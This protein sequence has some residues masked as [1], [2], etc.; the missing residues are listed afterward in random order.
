MLAHDAGDQ[1]RRSLF[2]VQSRGGLLVHPTDARTLGGRHIALGGQ[3]KVSLRHESIIVLDAAKDGKG[4][5]LAEPWRRLHQFRIRLWNSVNGLGWARPIVVID[6][7][8]PIL[9][10]P[11][12]SVI[13]G[14]PGTADLF[15]SA[16]RW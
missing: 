7:P 9:P 6:N 8:R 2:E 15:R 11:E 14:I 4:H 10:I 3:P 16:N 5:E 13:R 1:T 12:K